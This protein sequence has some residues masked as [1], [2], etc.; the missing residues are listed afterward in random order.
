M[1]EYN[2][3]N[4]RFK[5][6][7]EEALVHGAYRAKQTVNAAWKA[8]NLFEEFTGRM[9]FTTFNTEQA[10][11]FKRWLEKQKNKKG[12][13]LSISTVRSTLANVR[14]FFKWLA[15]HP[16]CIRKVD[17]RAAMYL[18][19]SN[20]D[21]RASRATREAPVPTMDE[22][23]Q[24]LEKM[25][26]ETDVQKRDRAIIAFTA[27]TGIRDD[28]LVTM[29]IKNVDIEKREIWQNPRNV[30]TK[31]RK[32]IITYFMAFDPLW[33]AIFTDW[34]KYATETLGFKPDDALFP[35]QLV[36]NNPEKMTFEAAGLSREHWA[37]AQT[38]REIFKEAF[39]SAGLPYYIPHSFRKTLVLWAMENCSQYQFKAI[40]QNIGHE[41]AVTSYNAYGKIAINDQRKAVFSIEENNSDLKGISSE[42]LVAELGRRTQK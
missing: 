25:L 15:M 32:S 16:K 22:I 42:D 36:K 7:Y 2:P 39:T 19:L 24:T 28:A 8:I 21:E 40:S 31:N 6:Q 12:E 34:Y 29:K 5:K 1:S 13:P 33:E 26:Y 18:R 41:Q 14:E 9:D 20:N 3:L 30:R 4:E 11:G 35:K 17:A 38:V 27:L 23:R 37:G 10:K